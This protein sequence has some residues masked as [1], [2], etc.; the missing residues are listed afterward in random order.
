MK[1]GRLLGPNIQHRKVSTMLDLRMI[2]DGDA[3]L[4]SHLCGLRSAFYDFLG[5][6]ITL[7]LFIFSI[8]HAVVRIIYN[9]FGLLVWWLGVVIVLLEVVQTTTRR[10]SAE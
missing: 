10:K 3:A 9:L 1:W 5:A 7:L 4:Q 8:I 6:L 2:T